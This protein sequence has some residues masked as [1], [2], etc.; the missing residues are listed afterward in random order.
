[1]AFFLSTKRPGQFP[2]SSSQTANSSADS[3]ACPG[4]TDRCIVCLVTVLLIDFAVVDS[5]QRGML[6][7]YLQGLLTAQGAGVVS[8]QFGLQASGALD[9]EGR[10][11]L[12]GGDTDRLGEIV[13]EVSPERVVFSHRP[14]PACLQVVAEAGTGAKDASPVVHWFDFFENQRADEARWA[15]TLGVTTQQ[16]LRATPDYGYLA[17]NVAA[18][19]LRPLPYVLLGQPCE[20]R[21]DVAKNPVFRGLDLPEIVLAKGCAFCTIRLAEDAPRLDVGAARVAL[22]AALETSPWAGF[23]RRICL[24][25]EQVLGQLPS[26]AQ[27]VVELQP[28]GEVDLL[29]SSRV[30]R[31]VARK[32]RIHQA[33]RL[34]EHTGHRIQWN[35]FGVENY[36]PVELKRMNK[37]IG[38]IATLEMLHLARSFARRFPDV[39]DIEEY[40]GL[41]MILFTPWTTLQDLRYNYHLIQQ[42][43]LEQISSKL[44]DSRLRLYETTPLFWLAKRD[45]LLT[46]CYEDPLFERAQRSFYEKEAPWRFADPQVEAFNR[47]SMRLAQAQTLGAMDSEDALTAQVRAWRESRG[48]RSEVELAMELLHLLEQTKEV[49]PHRLLETPNTAP[50]TARH[51]GTRASMVSPPGQTWHQERELFA[52][53]G[54]QAGKLEIDLAQ[55]ETVVAEA[56]RHFSVVEPREKDDGGLDVFF[57]QDPAAVEALITTSQEFYRRNQQATVAQVIKRIGE[58][59]GYPPCC[60]EA[61]CQEQLFG[62]PPWDYDFLLRRYQTPG[63]ISRLVNPI[64]FG[65]VYVPCS[66]HCSQTVSVLERLRAVDRETAT[67]LPEGTLDLP[68]IFL[69]PLGLPNKPK[70]WWNYVVVEPTEEIGEADSFSYRPVAAFGDDPRLAHVQQSDRLTFD[71]GILTVYA[72]GEKRYAFCL[73]ANIW[74]HRRAFDV[75]FWRQLLGLHVYRHLDLAAQVWADPQRTATPPPRYLALLRVVRRILGG[76]TELERATGYCF[77]QATAGSQ[78]VVAR[79]EPTSGMETGS[80]QGV[81]PDGFMELVIQWRP[82]TDAYCA[83]GDQL[84]IGIRHAPQGDPRNPDRLAKAV[85]GLVERGL[86]KP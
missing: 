3:S 30:D 28:T 22:E 70:R 56:R 33:L 82:D 69:L 19:H 23:R 72:G 66:C 45:G 43:G 32:D 65:P 36:S 58:L 40:G 62:L 38:P 10:V 77:T 57:G 34:F 24:V 9:S 39:F 49:D 78:L 76:T 2:G 21:R 18:R 50:P 35:L 64:L 83:V 29:L 1:M 42:A 17:A 73:E 48:E 81:D 86:S 46:D 4:C 5:F 52:I 85:L 74:Y 13:G 54:R 11:Q 44:L 7:P 14:S 84:A 79:F 51:G 80:I 59:L 37:G 6:M 16:L 60:V 47:I 71:R 75:Q 68:V 25:G 12:T 61:Y 31:F 27:A 20:Y 26:L 15:E 55:G 8:Y 67:G 53:A 63:Q 41:S